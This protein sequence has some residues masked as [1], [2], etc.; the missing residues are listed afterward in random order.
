MQ[1]GIGEIG[2]S[3]LPWAVHNLKFLL[4]EASGETLKSR[5]AIMPGVIVAGLE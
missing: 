4:S 1:V 3:D 5:A 2:S